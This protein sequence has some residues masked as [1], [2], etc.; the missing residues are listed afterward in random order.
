MRAMHAGLVA[1][2]LGDAPQVGQE[3]FTVDPGHRRILA[4]SC[5]SGPLPATFPPAR[6]GGMPR[7]VLAVSLLL[8]AVACAPPP[9]H[10]QKP[11]VADAGRDEAE[12]RAAARDEAARRLPYGN[13]PPI[14]FYPKMSMLQWTQGIDNE[15]SYLAEQLMRICMRDRGFE[16]T[17]VT[18]AAASSP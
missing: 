1:A 3:S 2:E 13:G 4:D 11:G 15:R 18:P 10:W 16:L 14:F 7:R 12:C 17:R 9:M 6:I 8:A 5:R